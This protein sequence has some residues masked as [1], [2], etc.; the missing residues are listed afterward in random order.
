MERICR[1]ERYVDRI[2]DCFFILSFPRPNALS[3][4]LF[5]PSLPL[6]SPLSS[7][8]LSYLSNNKILCQFSDNGF[9]DG[10]LTWWEPTKIKNQ[11]VLA[12]IN[13]CFDISY[14]DMANFSLI[15]HWTQE[16]IWFKITF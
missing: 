14:R 12:E 7:I 5:S 6:T 2:F 4:F 1:D 3:P 10:P 9:L 15:C 13:K 11:V 16:K 8:C